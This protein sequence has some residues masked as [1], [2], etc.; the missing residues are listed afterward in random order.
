M[1]NAKKLRV[2]IEPSVVSVGRVS[3][4]ARWR[5]DAPQEETTFRVFGRNF[6]LVVKDIN[7]SR[8]VQ[9]KEGDTIHYTFE[10]SSQDGVAK[11][12]VEV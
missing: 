1:A 8:L 4:N 12:T 10:G 11:E 7:E 6:V 3:N 2:N 9:I 5:E